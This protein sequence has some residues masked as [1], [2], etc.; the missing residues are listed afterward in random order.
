MI[1]ISG[2]KTYYC[3]FLKNFFNKSGFANRLERAKFLDLKHKE[4][5]L[6]SWDEKLKRK[7][8]CYSSNKCKSGKVIIVDKLPSKEIPGWPLSKF[9]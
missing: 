5:D 7:R 4:D 3:I 1:D 2:T 8:Y 6:V 9:K